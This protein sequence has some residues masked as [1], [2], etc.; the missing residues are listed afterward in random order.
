MQNWRII[1]HDGREA[2]VSIAMSAVFPYMEIA[3]AA[4]TNG[5][6]LFR[7]EAAP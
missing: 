4:K 6:R 7:V 1:S 2:L 5:F 3:K